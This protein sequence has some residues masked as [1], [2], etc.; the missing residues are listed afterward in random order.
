MS[1]YSYL[2]HGDS[3]FFLANLFRVGKSTTYTIIHEVCP[4]IWEVLSPTYLAWKSAEELSI[5]AQGFQ[6]MWNFP[7]CLAALD[8]KELRIR[9]PPRSGSM[10]YNYKKLLSF[11]VLAICDAFY[12]FMWVNIGDFGKKM[13]NTIKIINL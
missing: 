13:L 9:S 10:F 12:R 8:G 5:V 2:G 7:N 6:T 3:M 4:L 11:K 1:Y